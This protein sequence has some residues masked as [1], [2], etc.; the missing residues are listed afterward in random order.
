MLILDAVGK[1]Y[2]QRF[3]QA[4]S[5]HVNIYP[6]TKANGIFFTNISISFMLLHARLFRTV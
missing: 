1:E 3:K 6:P 4:P 2:L 5:T